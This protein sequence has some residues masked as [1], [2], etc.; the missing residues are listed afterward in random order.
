MNL[1]SLFPTLTQLAGLLRDC[2]RQQDVLARLGG[3]EFGVLLRD[4]SV[5]DAEQVESAL[6]NELI[7]GGCHGG[8]SRLDSRLRV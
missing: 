3:D 2:L 8:Q 1:L 6:P 7:R 5:A 4:C